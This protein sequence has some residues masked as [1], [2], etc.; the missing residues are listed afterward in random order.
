VIGSPDLLQLTRGEA[1]E[2]GPAFSP[3]GGTMSFFRVLGKRLLF[4][5][6]SAIGGPERVVAELPFFEC[7]AHQAF[8]CLSSTW[9]P[10][11]RSAIL[12]GLNKLSVE[13]GEMKPLTNPQAGL[14]DRNPSLS[15]DGRT[16]AFA[17]GAYSG[18]EIYLVGLDSEAKAK[19]PPRRLVARPQAGIRPAWTPDGK[20]VVFITGIQQFG[21]NIMKAPVEGDAAPVLLPY[22]KGQAWWGAGLAISPWH[23]RLAFGQIQI[24]S[25]LYR[26]PLSASGDASGPPAVF[27]PSTTYEANPQYS[28]DGK[29]VVFQSSRSG[30]SGIWM[31]DADASNIVELYAKPGVHAGSPAWS[32]DGENIVFDSNARGKWDI[33]IVRAA[34]GQPRIVRSDKGNNAI[35]AWS[36]DGKWIIFDSDRTGN[37][38]IWKMPV[39]GGQAV[40]LTR[41]GGWVG[42]ESPD[43]KWLFY[44]KGEN[45][46]L[47]KM[48][49]AGGEEVIAVPSRIGRAEFVVTDQGVF[50]IEH[51]PD[52]SK[53]ADI[54]GGTEI[55]FLRFSTNQVKKIASVG[56][57]TEMG[58]TVSPDRRNIL[59]TQKESGVDLM[60]LENFL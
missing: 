21:S 14:F 13:T 19:G 42:L 37:L 7:G 60:L 35:P 9:L 43:G 44:T 8:Y 47:W 20:E 11:G 31:S 52:V 29:R 48:P 39:S 33:Y 22:G 25:H 57:L 36:R 58:L 17:R 30:N 49:A 1:D 12:P 41:K 54:P 32:P 24:H 10:D 38:E 23:N 18:T 26:L 15:P 50:F 5:T 28:P 53:R 16:L 40:Q 59:Y 27:A 55:R 2:Y 4:V 56:P 45:G 34:A 3:D 6:E 51:N 46:P